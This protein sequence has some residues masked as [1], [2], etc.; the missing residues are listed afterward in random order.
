[1]ISAMF[2]SLGL[3]GVVRGFEID[4]SGNVITIGPGLAV[5]NGSAVSTPAQ[6]DMAT[7][8][9]GIY[10]I[11]IDGELKLADQYDPDIFLLYVVF[12]W[13]GQITVVHDVRTW[14][15]VAVWCGT[16]NDCRAQINIGEGSR[17]IAMSF[18]VQD[19]TS[20]WHN[21]NRVANQHK[22]GLF[23]MT[24]SLVPQ[25]GCIGAAA[26]VQFKKY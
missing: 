15:L 11:N 10:Y 16:G 18:A 23:D 21:I 4:I 25:R 14:L 20:K 8:P 13:G 26:A 17:A 5:V 19:N 22:A 24:F 3:W 1:M 2:N 7:R 9:A 12:K 6:W